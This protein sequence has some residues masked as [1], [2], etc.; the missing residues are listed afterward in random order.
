MFR[1]AFLLLKPHSRMDNVHRNTRP[2]YST[3]FHDIRTSILSLNR[4]IFV[5]LLLIDITA[6]EIIYC[7]LKINDFLRR[8]KTLGD[9]HLNIPT[10]FTHINNL[11]HLT[12]SLKTMHLKTL[13]LT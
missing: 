12:N 6:S 3:E 7:N 1:Y 9:T 13:I 4:N 10:Y 11:Q 2:V 5:H 8:S